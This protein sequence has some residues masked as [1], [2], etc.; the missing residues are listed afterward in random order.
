MPDLLRR[1]AR[2]G[3]G[4]D[5]GLEG[6]GAGRPHDPGAL[7]HLLGLPPGLLHGGHERG[8]RH[9]TATGWDARVVAMGAR[10]VSRQGASVCRRFW[11]PFCWPR[12]T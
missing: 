9:L 12:A 6:A 3:A 10:L 7:L 4:L 11:R 1:T 8:V 5:A 2:L